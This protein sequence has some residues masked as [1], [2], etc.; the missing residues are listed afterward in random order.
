V[1][2]LQAQKEATDLLAVLGAI[3]PFTLS[4]RKNKSNVQ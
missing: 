4:I 3:F 2:A 1:A